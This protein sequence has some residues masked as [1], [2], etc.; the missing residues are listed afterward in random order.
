MINFLC[1]ISGMSRQ[2]YYKWKGQTPIE[3]EQTP[4][5]QVI[6]LALEVRK[7]YLPGSSARELYYYIRKHPYLDVQL[8][9]W[10]KHNFEALC[11]DNGMRI[12]YLRF[13]PKTTQR[14][15]FVFDNQIAGKQ[16]VD[17]NTILVSDICYIFG[18]QGQ[19]I[20]YATTLM[21]VYS[22]LLLGLHFSQTMQSIDTVIP[23][24]KQAI[25]IRKKESLHGAFFHSDGG[26]QYISSAFLKLIDSQKMTSS[27]AAICY[28]NPH[29]E[30]LNDT[31]KNHMLTDLNLNSFHQL[32]KKEKFIKRVYNHNKVHSALGRITPT[33]FELQLKTIKTCQRTKLIIKEVL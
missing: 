24:F 19:R 28:E 3:K 9:G 10:S 12:K 33:E 31:L 30:A 18:H 6:A 14:G 16:I 17:I 4:A 15:S 5:H 32:K 26:K 23:V 13:I 11:L 8:Q 2:N 29:A 20:G 21:D 27:M 22:R 1:R 7:K 25:S